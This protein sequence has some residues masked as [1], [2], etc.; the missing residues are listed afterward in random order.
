MDSAVFRLSPTVKGKLSE[1]CGPERVI[2]EPERLID[3][4]HDESPCPACLPAVVVKPVNSGEVARVM[5]LARN[6]RIPVTPRG[7]GTGLAGGSVPVQGGMVISL[8]LM[9]SILEVDSENLMV[10]TQPG[11]ITA[12]LQRRCA[13][14]GLYYPVD[15]ASLD[16]CSIGGNVATNAGG[17]RAF[18]YGVTGDYVTGIQAVLADGSVISYGGKLRKNATGYD[19]NRLLVGSEGTLGIIT[20]IT[21]RLVP[22]PRARIDLLIPFRNL[23][24]GVELVLK[25]VQEERLVP[26]VVEFFEQQ[27]AEACRQVLG[28]SLPFPQAAVQVLVELEGN[29]LAEV[30]ADALRLGAMAMAMGADEPLIAEDAASQNRLWTTRRSLAKTLK[31]LYPEVVAEDIVV[32]P[33][34]LAETVEFISQLAVR[35]QL[36]IVPFGHIGDGNIHVDFCR[37]TAERE[38]WQQ[39][40]QQAVDELIDFVVGVGGQITAEH[41]IGALKKRLLKKGL[42]PAE[43]RLMRR[44][45]SALDPDNLLNPGKIFPED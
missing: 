19:L 14:F 37:T 30:S 27:G 8:E 40:T 41:G 25:L 35:F 38:R 20:E 11:V 17:A 42:G 6:E 39:R 26:A 12:E 13:G 28:E 34:R 9:N 15:P 36:M 16:D 2:T 44:L 7:L 21:F 33:A 4:S 5:E 24:S 18:K 23:R 10:R 31:K 1:I 29:E 43:I 32:P 22:R 45:K 3:Y